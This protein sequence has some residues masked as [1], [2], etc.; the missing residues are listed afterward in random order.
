MQVVGDAVGDTL[1]CGRGAG[2]MPTASAV[3]ADLV[4]VATGTTP[5]LFKRL[6]IFPDSASPAMVLP[7]DD[8]QSRYYLRL[9]ARDVPGVMA[10]VALAL[11]DHHISLSGIH[12]RET[13][14]SQFVPVVITTH[15]AREGDLR[16]A[17]RV[18]DA[19]P[20][21]QPPTVCLRVIDQP[22][23]FSQG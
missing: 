7:I 20:T 22:K 11:G 18:I 10:Q 21:I 4:G 12:Q 14:A 5:V 16:Q 15:M 8:L 2:Q 3:V 9:T 13:D 17:L 23:E 1:Y 6:N 19:L